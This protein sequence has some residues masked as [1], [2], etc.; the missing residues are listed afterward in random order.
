MDRQNKEQLVDSM[1]Q[2]L[3]S[4]SLVVVTHQSGLTVDEAS[5]LRRKVREAGASYKVLKN[6]LARL[7]LAD[8]DHSELSEIMKGPTAL[9]YS[10]DPVAAAKAVANFA[11][12]NEKLSIVGGSMGQG[13][14]DTS[15]IQALAKLP[16]LDELRAKLVAMLQ[17]PATKVAS[18]TVAPAGQL[19]RVFSAY[20]AKG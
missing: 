19:A 10:E 15:Q 12:E 9:A 14:M 5:E 8:T 6:T 3:A 13:A 18:V 16:S 17:T 7:A 11:K 2:A 20:G 1:R 4:S